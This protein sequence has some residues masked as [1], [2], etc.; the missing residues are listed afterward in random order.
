[1]IRIRLIIAKPVLLLLFVFGAV[2]TAQAHSAQHQDSLLNLLAKETALTS[3]RVDRLNQLGYNYWISDP[4]ASVRYGSQALE[5]AKV[6]PYPAGEAYA[7]RVVGVAHWAKGNLDL[8]FKFLME[9]RRSYKELDD[10]LGLANSSLNIGMAYADQGNYPLAEKNYEQALD[11]FK[12]KQKDSRVATTFTKIADALLLQEKYQPAFEYLNRALTIHRRT[13]FLYGIAEVNRKLGKL[14]AAKG[15]MDDAISYFLLAVEVGKKRNDQVGL[16]Q[17]Y[18][19]I[20]SA[21]LSKQERGLAEDYL[22]RSQKIA[23]ESGLQS[24]RRDLYATFKKLEEQRG[25]YR[26]ALAF[27]DI[28]LQVRDSLFTQEKSNLIANLEARRAFE[29]KEEELLLAQ[30]NLD[31]MVKENRISQLTKLLL[32]LILL[33]AV[34]VAYTLIARKNTVIDEN[35]ADL[36]K[37]Q[38]QKENLETALLSKEQ[39]LTSY[40][41]NFVQKN[42][43]ISALKRLTDSLGKDLGKEHRSKLR[44][45]TRQL[46]NLLNVDEDWEDFRRHFENVHPNLITSLNKAF[47]GLTQNDFRLIALIR[48]NLTTRETSTVLGISPDS[49][50]TARYR[51][52]K[53][54]GLESGENLLDFLL[55]QEQ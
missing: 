27:G 3:L 49:V 50:K 13:G 52:R 7:N 42:E 40:T 17:N 16:A 43:G 48:L 36:E 21:Y 25:N 51:L 26:Q 39:E 14:A 35:Y 22:K 24:V 19:G 20:G 34:G 54:L 5:I 8:S 1:M 29:A 4:G 10:S 28:Y 12:R 33:L 11:I 44:G 9:A 55:K 30:K 31:L 47:P 23:E 32:V 37:A 15:E 2:C 38:Q 53:K 6:L 41:L 45:I 18:L 46:D